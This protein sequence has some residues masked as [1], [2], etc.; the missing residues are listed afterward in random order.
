MVRFRNLQN[1]NKFDI[2]WAFKVLLFIIFDLI[3]FDIY[4]L[5]YILL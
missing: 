5:K 2:K 3:F 1:N 4:N